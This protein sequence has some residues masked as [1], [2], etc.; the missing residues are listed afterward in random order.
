MKK[1]SLLVFALAALGV[2]LF[3]AAVH[4]TQ[5]APETMTMNSGVYAKHTKT[6]VTFTHKKHNVD[7]KITCSDC[8]HLYEGGKNVWKEGSEVKKCEACHTEAKAPKD[9]KTPKAEKITKYHYS[10]IHANCQGC[11]KELKK[12]GK[13]TGPTACKDCHP[14]AQ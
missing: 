9:D 5:G 11:H 3:F 4:A 10:A 8:H 13:P 12:T 14:K 6:L 7:Y 1:L 2:V